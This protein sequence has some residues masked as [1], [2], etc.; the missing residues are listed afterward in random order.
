MNET[1]IQESLSKLAKASSASLIMVVLGVIFLAG[2]VYYSATRLTPLQ[3]QIQA[4]EAKR[5]ELRSSVA[6]FSKA[7]KPVST[8]AENI[9]AWMYVGRVA[10]GGQ[11]A[12]H[13][14]GIVPAPNA[15]ETVEIK[16]ILTKSNSRFVES[17]DESSDSSAS[18]KSDGPIQLVRGGTQ[19]A[20]MEIRRLPSVGN[21]LFIWVKVKIPSSA[22]LELP[23]A[24]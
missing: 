11:W 13:A 21:G 18:S 4:L 10:D 3:E 7:A 23:S 22:V 12:P 1:E 2:S 17:P 16:S 6:E 24:S 19:M 14:D 15:A 20:V 9:E 5:D 8:P